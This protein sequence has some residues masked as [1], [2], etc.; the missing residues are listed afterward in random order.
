MSATLL[1]H[2]SAALAALDEVPRAA[3]TFHALT[4]AELLSLTTIAASIQRLATTQ[5]SLVAG[6]IARRSSRELGHSGL[7][8]REGFRNAEELVRSATGST[9]VEAARAVRVGALVHDA[10]PWLMPVVN[11]VVEGSLSAAAADAI[12]G[13]LGE[14][15]TEISSSALADAAGQLCAESSG[16]DADQLQRRA[17]ELRNELDEAGIADREAA[18]REQRSLRFTKLA[19]GMSLL[20]WRMDPETAASVGELYDRATSPRRGG[21]RFVDSDLAESIASDFR[22]TEQLASDVF[23][24][25]LRHGAA[26]D[27]TRLLGSGAPVVRVVTIASHGFIEGQHDAVSPETVERLGC[28]G[29]VQRVT[30][31]PQGQPLDLGR[32]QRLFSKHQ[33][34]ALAIRDGGC[35]WPGCDRPPSWT[36][37]HHTEHWARDRGTTDVA[38][39]IL[40]CRYHH[41]TL[42][43]NHWQIR[44]RGAVFELIPPPG[45]DSAQ[46]PRPM[47]TKS[48]VL[49]EVV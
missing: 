47:P 31:D 42:H 22:S 16:L 35:R 29:S 48:A 17:R 4:D 14:P 27:S 33:R 28:A 46:R 19:D 23:A 40:L 2:A 18:R 5:G 20:S 13:G 24:E 21:P 44:K 7:A 30:F 43:N 49:R 3:S 8:Q 25:L 34:V 9:G 41:L 37:A 39:G 32:E 1:T 11:A 38:N 10:S 36:E 15:G 12:R 6:E 26:V 45:V